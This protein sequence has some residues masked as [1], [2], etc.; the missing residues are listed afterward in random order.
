M[1]CRAIAAAA[2]VGAVNAVSL[3]R[4]SCPPLSVNYTAPIPAQGYTYRLV[5]H[6]L[7]KPRS[8]AFDDAGALLVVDSGV[9]VVRMTTK[10]NGGTCVVVGAPQPI[11]NSTEVCLNAGP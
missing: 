5:A 7:T 2:A 6:G 8:I 9:G 10:D 4:D 3:P 1:R 11:I